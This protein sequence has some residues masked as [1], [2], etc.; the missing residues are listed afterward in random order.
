MKSSLSVGGAVVLN[1]TLSVKGDATIENNLS[2]GDDLTMDG[3]STI[4]TNKLQTVGAN[5]DMVLDLGTNRDGT[6]T[7]NGNLNILGALNNIGVDVTN[8]QVEDKTITLATYSTEGGDVPGGQQ[9][10]NADGWNNK[11]G[12]NIEGIPSKFNSNHQTYNHPNVGNV[13]EKSFLWN[14][15]EN[16]S[17]IGGMQQ[18]PMC[19]L[20]SVQS[21]YGYTNDQ[22][23]N[24]H[25]IDH[26]SFWELKGGALRLSSVIENANGDLEK[27]SYSMRITK[28]KELQFVKHEYTYDENNNNE[29][30]KKTPIQVATFGVSFI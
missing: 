20:T 29:Y 22:L 23:K 27:I 13:W 21:Q 6:L 24:S 11:S 1:S 3:N 25:N 12:I 28:N 19:T 14:K 4:F 2:I 16:N 10:I 5:S 9:Y 26:E 17:E 15:N 7:V 18:G 30:I 8:L